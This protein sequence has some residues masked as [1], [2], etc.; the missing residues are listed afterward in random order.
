[1]L[2]ALTYS[3]VLRMPLPLGPLRMGSMDSMGLYRRKGRRASFNLQCRV[4]PTVS[5]VH[6]LDCKRLFDEACSIYNA[7]A[8][9]AVGCLVVRESASKQVSSVIK[10]AAAG[11]V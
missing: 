5:F 6:S 9:Y 4:A 2:M 7:R 10:A 11:G 8:F 1:M 3:S